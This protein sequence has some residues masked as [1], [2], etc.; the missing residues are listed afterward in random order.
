MIQ[1]AIVWSILYPITL[2]GYLCMSLARVAWF[3][4]NSPVDVWHMIGESI[5]EERTE[6]QQDATD[7]QR[8]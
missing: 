1:Q 3:L 6:K 4:F 8:M 5:Q 2:I 7:D